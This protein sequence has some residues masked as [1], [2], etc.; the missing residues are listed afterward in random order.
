MDFFNF[1]SFSKKYKDNE[2]SSRI[3]QNFSPLVGL[4]KPNIIP[5]VVVLPH[6][7]G[8]SKPRIS[9]SFMLKLISFTAS[10]LEKFL[11]RL[12]TL[13]KVFIYFFEEAFRSLSFIANPTA[14]PSLMPVSL[15]KATSQRM[16]SSCS[17]HDCCI[18]L[19]ISKG[20]ETRFLLS[21]SG[22]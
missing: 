1:G 5:I 10:K 7:F 16:S 17:K 18:C 12:F 21:A 2:R 14:S 3:N 8:P 15:N 13:T 11:D 20:M 9:L 22:I 19:I 6:P 4:N